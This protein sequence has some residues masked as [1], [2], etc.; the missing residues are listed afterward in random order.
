MQPP[1]KNISTAAAVFF[2]TSDHVGMD[3]FTLWWIKAVYTRSPQKKSCGSVITGLSGHVRVTDSLDSL[4]THLLTPIN[5]SEL[6]D[7]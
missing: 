6:F 3:P 1:K 2:S 4:Y 5:Y 7:R